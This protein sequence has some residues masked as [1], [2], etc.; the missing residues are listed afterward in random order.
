MASQGE[1]SEQELNDVLSLLGN[2][3]S[4][5]ESSEELLDLDTEAFND[6]HALD[7]LDARETVE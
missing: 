1:I 5:A 3:K 4:V 6:P 7:D 2:S